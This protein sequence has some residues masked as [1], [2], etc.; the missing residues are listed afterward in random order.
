[1]ALPNFGNPISMNQVNVELNLAGTTTISL[2]QA[3]VR[4]LFQ[5]ASGAI[6]MYDGF[7]KSNAYLA[8]VNAYTSTPSYRCYNWSFENNISWYINSGTGPISVYLEIAPTYTNASPGNANGTPH[9]TSFCT[10]FEHS[11]LGTV[12]PGTWV[13]VSAKDFGL[14][15][16]STASYNRTYRLRMENA[17]G[18]SYSPN[19][20]VAFNPCD[21]YD[22]CSATNN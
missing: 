16:P 19:I 13:D 14:S 20:G 1:M 22:Y 17:A 6:S 7:G 21:Q 9:P 11:L 2:N 4:T 3:S 12:S 18:T 15:S 8:T 10:F 5:I